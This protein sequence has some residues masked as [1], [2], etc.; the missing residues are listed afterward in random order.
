MK[1][2]I[3]PVLFLTFVL[4]L[5]GCGKQTE[6]PPVGTKPTVAAEVGTFGTFEAKDLQGNAV[7]ES[8][9]AGHNVTMV[10]IW[11]TFCSP[12]IRE[13]PD[14]AKLHNEYEGLQVVGI[15]IDAVD[16]NGKVITEKYNS[17]IGIIKST[18]ATY[19]HLLPSASLTKCCLKDVTSIPVTFFVDS[20]G[21][22][23]GETYVGSRNYQQWKSIIDALPLS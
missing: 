12:C 10:N 16:G 7:T 20:N 23:I 21:N 3:L 4:L 6:Q 15:V 11:G 9:F 17:A 14:L 1:K 2:N 13:M 22:V 19:T 8:I 5:G 18:G